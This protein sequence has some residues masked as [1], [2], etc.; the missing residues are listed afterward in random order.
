MQSIE[1]DSRISSE[2]SSYELNAPTPGL[3]MLNPDMF[4]EDYRL[5]MAD[6][7]LGAASIFKVMPYTDYVLLHY[8]DNYG[9]RGEKLWCLY[10]KCCRRD[11][12]KFKLVMHMFGDRCFSQND[13]DENLGPDD[14]FFIPFID[15]GTL[16]QFPDQ[17]FGPNYGNE[18]LDFC[19]KNTEIFIQ[20]INMF[21]ETRDRN[22]AQESQNS[23]MLKIGD[24][25]FS[26]YDPKW[27]ECA[28]EKKYN[29]SNSSENL[30]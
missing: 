15:D 6:G 14:A 23:Q 13:I 12:K 5:T 20:K 19:K 11:Y 2:R 24:N 28:K 26:L 1:N 10:D 9:V 18:W 29:L 27:I 17:N 4:F 16:S 30:Y 25:S 21:R 8:L 3:S 7:N 22:I